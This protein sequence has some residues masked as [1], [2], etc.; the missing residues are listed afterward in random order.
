MAGR[1]RYRLFEPPGARA[2]VPRL[3]V[4]LRGARRPLWDPLA[5]VLVT[6]AVAC[7]GVV[8]AVLRSLP[9]HRAMPERRLRLLGNPSSVAAHAFE[10]VKCPPCRR[11]RHALGKEGCSPHFKQ[12]GEIGFW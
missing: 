12:R 8:M 5:A 9:N 2:S 1:L 11:V 4:S 6:V 7:V 3:W 10:H